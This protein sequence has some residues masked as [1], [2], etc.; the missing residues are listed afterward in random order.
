M[1]HFFERGVTATAIYKAT[2]HNY[3]SK[4]NIHHFLISAVN[5][6]GCSVFWGQDSGIRATYLKDHV[7]L[8]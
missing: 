2:S 1:I 7:V 3:T 8:V 5:V 6:T 4:F